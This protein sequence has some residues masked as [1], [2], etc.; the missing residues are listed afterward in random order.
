MNHRLFKIALA[1]V[2]SAAILAVLAF[3]ILGNR[4]NRTRTTEAAPASAPTLAVPSATTNSLLP[5]EPS[6]IA[7]ATASTTETSVSLHQPQRRPPNPWR[8]RW[9]NLS[10]HV[11]AQL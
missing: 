11:A 9:R 10:P 8:R 7:T 2:G 4:E 1:G 3:V 6:V 5:A